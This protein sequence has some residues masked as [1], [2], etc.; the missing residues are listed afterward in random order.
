MSDDE[1]IYP[2]Q[3][4]E[5]PPTPL[6]IH[7]STI[8][9]VRTE[10]KIDAEELRMIVRLRAWTTKALFETTTAFAFNPTLQNREKLIA[11]IEE[12]SVHWNVVEQRITGQEFFKSF[13]K[14]EQDGAQIS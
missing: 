8:H 4:R 5:S 3:K 11:K 13:V 9:S 14:E 2:S 7:S 1:T 10:D 12:Y 6:T